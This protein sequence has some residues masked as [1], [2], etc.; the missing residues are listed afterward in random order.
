MRRFR[1]ILIGIGAAGLIFIGAL[2][3]YYALGD[4]YP[5]RFG[6]VVP[7]KIYRS[8]QPNPH[9]LQRVQQDIGIKTIINLRGEHVYKRDRHCRQEA[10]FAKKNGIKVVVIGF[11]NPP[12]DENVR[13]L[14]NVLDGPKNRPILIHCKQG[15][16]R[17]GLAVAVYRLERMGWTTGQAVR[18]MLT[19]D[20]AADLRHLENY[21]ESIFIAEYKPMHPAQESKP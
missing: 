15:L 19:N 2:I 4:R 9:G 6:V 20:F 8:A 12:T 14:L 17:T 16:E 7:G 21:D 18:E 13:D 5:Q 1:K 3:C 10:H 11:R